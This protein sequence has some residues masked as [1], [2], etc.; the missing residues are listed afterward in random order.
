MKND[1]GAPGLHVMTD[2]NEDKGVMRFLPMVSTQLIGVT[3]RVLGGGKGGEF[4]ARSKR[5]I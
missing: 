3:L 2:V 4:L 1:L 5:K